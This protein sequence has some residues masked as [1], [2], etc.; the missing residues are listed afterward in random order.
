MLLGVYNLMFMFL[1]LLD[2]FFSS[3]ELNISSCTLLVGSYQVIIM[4][5]LIII[6]PT[7]LKTC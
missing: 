1:D 2:T 5:K 7:T 3:N 4:Y 6:V